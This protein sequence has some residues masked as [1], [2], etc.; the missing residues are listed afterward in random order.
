[1]VLAGGLGDGR[2]HLGLVAQR[3]RAPGRRD[4]PRVGD[5]RPRL[6]TEGQRVAGP[7]GDLAALG[8]QRDVGDRL[9]LGSGGQGAGLHG[10][11]DHQLQRGH[12]EGQHQHDP[13]D[14]QPPRVGAGTGRAATGRR[15]P[16]WCGASRTGPGPGWG[17]CHQPVP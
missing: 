12:A 2:R 8:G 4:Q 17:R 15:P 16:G 3:V 11:D 1:M 14:L 5:Q 10:L 9:P 6:G 13:T 7:V